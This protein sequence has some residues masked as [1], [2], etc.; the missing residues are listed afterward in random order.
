MTKSYFKD[1]FGEYIREFWQNKKGM[2][3]HEKKMKKN[4]WLVMN[5][6]LNL[7]THVIYIKWF[8]SFDGNIETTKNILAARH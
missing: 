5:W 4:G 6:S 1:S 3:S 8:K 2:V 7:E